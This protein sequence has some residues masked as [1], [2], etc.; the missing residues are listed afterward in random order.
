M[1]TVIN[2]LTIEPKAEP[3]RKDAQQGGDQGGGG[4]KAAPEV[5]REIRKVSMRE[6]DRALRARA[7]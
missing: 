6:H 1:P 3:P 5:E 2:D 4:A 7:Y